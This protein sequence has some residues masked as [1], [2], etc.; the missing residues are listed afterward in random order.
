MAVWKHRNKWRA[1]IYVDGMRIAA[2][3]GFERKKDAPSWHDTIT[4]QYRVDPTKF[5]KVKDQKSF[6]D[7]FTMFTEL[8]LPTIRPSTQQRYLIDID[9]RIAPFFAHMKLERISSTMIESFKIQ[10][11]GQLKPKSVNNCLLHSS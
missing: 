9:Q 10:W 4:V 5:E 11:M 7:L 8:H 6:E 3:S 1:E 2:R